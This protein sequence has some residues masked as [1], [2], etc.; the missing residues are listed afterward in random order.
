[1][2]ICVRLPLLHC[3]P[4]RVRG[5]N[6]PQEPV[7]SQQQTRALPC[8]CYQRNTF[9]QSPSVHHSCQVQMFPCKQVLQQTTGD[10]YLI[11]PLQR[12]SNNLV[13]G[14]THVM[15]CNM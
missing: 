9:L 2:C 3:G 10:Q 5:Q 1:M 12:V 14:V 4:D 7:L 6:C 15:R 8:Y 13:N 11:T